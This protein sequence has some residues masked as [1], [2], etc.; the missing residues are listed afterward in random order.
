MKTSRSLVIACSMDSNLM[1]NWNSS[2]EPRKLCGHKRMLSHPERFNL[3]P[4]KCPGCP[5]QHSFCRIWPEAWTTCNSLHKSGE[6]TTLSGWTWAS[7]SPFSSWQVPIH[8]GL[9]YSTPLELPSE[10]ILAYLILSG[11][12]WVFSLTWPECISCWLGDP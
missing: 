10:G 1:I 5:I 8:A 2:F 4:C 3:L 9:Q 12:L 6:S 7:T 11:D